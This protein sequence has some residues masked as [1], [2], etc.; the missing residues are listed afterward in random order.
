MH[1]ATEVKSTI[2]V[3]KFGCIPV[4][5]INFAIPTTTGLKILRSLKGEPIIRLKMQG[6]YFLCERQRMICDGY[7]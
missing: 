2:I 3:M 1:A 4:L 5:F 6:L 7:F